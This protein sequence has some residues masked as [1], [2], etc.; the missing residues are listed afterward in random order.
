MKT[1]EAETDTIEGRN[2]WAIIVGDF[3]TPLT[4]TDR[5]PDRTYIRKKSV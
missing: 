4:N 5:N 3:N 2:S 1:H